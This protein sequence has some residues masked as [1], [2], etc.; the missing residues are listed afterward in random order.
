MSGCDGCDGCDGYILYVGESIQ[1]VQNGKMGPKPKS[2]LAKNIYSRRFLII[3]IKKSNR[4]GK[5]T[6]ISLGIIKK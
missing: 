1:W 2:I 4:G 5:N 6:S 3:L